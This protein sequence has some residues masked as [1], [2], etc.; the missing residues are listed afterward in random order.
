M[1]A[2]RSCLLVLVLLLSGL[3]GFAQQAE[4]KADASSWRLSIDPAASRV[5]FLLDATM[6]EVHGTFAVRS[7][8]L[9]LD[10]ASGRLE[11]EVVVDATSA[12]TGSEGRD[13]EMHEKVLESEKYPTIVFVPGAFEG[14]LSPGGESKGVLKGEMR[15]HGSTHAV[16]LPA[17]VKLEGERFTAQTS[18]TVP[19]V[20]WG[21]EDPSKFVFRVAKEVEVEVEVK[22][23]IAR[24]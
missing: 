10:P 8:S 11:G 16:S 21:L 6:H 5:T 4:P 20:E 9:R 24:P 13:E 3:P 14:K 12:E 18:F 23:T 1:R 15:I 19:Y 22:G 7:G 2:M 17:R